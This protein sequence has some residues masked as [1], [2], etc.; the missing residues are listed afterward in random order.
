MFAGL[1]EAAS[2]NQSPAFDVRPLAQTLGTA[3]CSGDAERRTRFQFE[4]LAKIA[5]RAAPAKVQSDLA[6]LHGDTRLAGT[7]FRPFCTADPG[8]AETALMDRA[9]AA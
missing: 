2:F 7:K 5:A 3:L 8:S 1:I 6:T 9:L 4:G